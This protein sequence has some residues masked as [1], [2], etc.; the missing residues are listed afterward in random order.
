MLDPARLTERHE[1]YFDLLPQL[2]DWGINTI[3]WHFSDDQGFAFRLRRH[4]QLASPHAFTRGEMQRFVAEA[5][6]L[7]IDVVPEVESL[8]HARY[9][10]RLP[11]YAHLADGEAGGFNAICPS[12]PETLP[13]LRQIIEEVAELFPSPYLHAGLDEV[14]LAGCQRCQRRGRGKPP[15]WIYLQHTLAIHGI[16]ADRG[17]RMVMWADHV[18]H[19][20]QLLAHLPRDIVLAHWQ[21]TDVREEPIR[22]SLGAG[23][24]V[25]CAPSMLHWGDVIQPNA[26][27]LDNMDRMTATGR[28]LAGRGVL[29]VVN[30]WWT[31]WRILRDAAMPA[32]AYTG[33][34][35]AAGAPIDKPRFMRSYL[36]Q[37][38]GIAQASVAAAMWDLHQSPIHM[39][40][41]RAL[42]FDSPLFMQ[43]AIAL[44][45]QPTFRPR[46]QRIES[47]IAA[48]E[49]ARPAVRSRREEYD[50]AIA[51]GHVAAKSLRIGLELLRA[52]E[53]YK[54]AQWLFNRDCGRGPVI[55]KLEEVAGTLAGMS[56]LVGDACELVEREWDRT[57]YRNDRKKGTTLLTTAAAPEDSLLARLA[58]C[59]RYLSGVLVRM[60]RAT[61]AYRRRGV[62]PTDGIC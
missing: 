56:G 58:R 54:A 30:T 11:H 43:E 3:W 16:L 1:F 29:G 40:E 46:L 36:R 7:D 47:A 55:A 15:W 17:K 35:L 18:E 22:R 12:H 44:A 51:A 5:H 24:K 59:R 41:L 60:G 20:P 62:F 31:P 50:A 33:R 27:N 49:R 19:D 6:R 52:A 4:P 32:V 39:N 9:I 53:A 28:R 14:S 8:G 34:L 45:R 61:A 13:L 23:F 38:H 26:A 21:Y 42:L 37:R 10:T 25:V 57:R 48:L 2:A